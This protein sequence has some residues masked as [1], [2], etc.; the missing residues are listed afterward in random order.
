MKIGVGINKNFMPP[1]P[2]VDANDPIVIT[3][4]GFVYAPGPRGTHIDFVCKV[5]D[6]RKV[7]GIDKVIDLL[8]YIVDPS[9]SLAVESYLIEN[10]VAQNELYN[11]L[12]N[13]GAGIITIS[14]TADSL[15]MSKQNA[16]ELL[17]R[18][19]QDGMLRK[20]YTYFMKTKKASTI[21]TK[22]ND[23]NP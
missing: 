22:V 7:E 5:T 13:M 20:K 23:A 14:Y 12:R 11:Y 2:N 3:E 17:E 9:S 4:D 16:R 15:N 21:L 18:L 8:G 1:Y 19:V 10:S 6:W